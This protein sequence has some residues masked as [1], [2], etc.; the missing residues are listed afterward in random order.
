MNEPV[1]KE[2]RERATSGHDVSMA[3]SA[4]AGSGKTTVLVRRIVETLVCGRVLPREVAA[5]TFTEKAAGELSAR[6]RDALEKK[7]REAGK[8]NIVEQILSELPELT[9]STIHTFCQDLLRHESLEAEFAPDTT[10]GNERAEEQILSELLVD[11]KT[12]F[13]ERRAEQARV[14]FELSSFHTLLR[15][16]KK[17]FQYR[18]YRDRTSD[19]AFDEGAAFSELK[20]IHAAIVKAMSP[21]KN[22]DGCKLIKKARALLDEVEGALK[23]PVSDGVFLCLTSDEAA[24]GRNVGSQK[25]WPGESK[26]AFLRE[27]AEVI[28][29]RTRWRAALHAAVI[30]DMREHLLPAFQEEKRRQS[31]AGF[32]DLLF[33]AAHLLKKSTA[34]RAR[35]AQRYKVILVDEVQDTDPIQAE[36]A[37]LLASAVPDDTIATTLRWEELSPS[38]GRLFAVGDPKQSIYRFRGADVDTFK[39]LVGAISKSGEQHELS[40]NFRSVP[41]IVSWVNYVFSELP[42][43]AAQEGHRKDAELSPVVA[44]YTPVTAAEGEEETEDGEDG[45]ES[46]DAPA[47]DDD[48]SGDADGELVI[49][50]IDAVIR[51]LSS[52]RAAQARVV[53]RES[54]ELR[55]LTWSDVMVLLP[56]WSMADTIAD[57]FRA[58][59]IECAVEGGDQFFVRD[60]VRLGTALLRAIVEPADTE[61]VVF[62]L[63]G[64]FG[65]SHDELATHK[66]LGGAFRYT[67]PNPPAGRVADALKVLLSAHR[68]RSS[69]SL[70]ELLDEVFSATRALS[71]WRLLPDG[72]SRLANIDKLLSMI[73]KAE[74]ECF[75]P[76]AVAEELMRQARVAKD[77]D[78]DRIDDDGDAVR[79][80]SL[81]KAKGLEASVVVMMFC[82]RGNGGMTSVVDHSARTIAVTLGARLLPSGWTELTASE[83]KLD[84]EER[85]RWMYVAATRARDQL[86][87]VPSKKQNLLDIEIKHRGLPKKPGKIDHGAPM[88]LTEGVVVN[89]EHASELPPIGA[90]LETFPGVDGLLESAL[91]VPA[92]RG[93]P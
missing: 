24:P 92:E 17:L 23:L 91:G 6:V 88:K 93:R 59:G 43:Y 70:V 29:W 46:G 8:S 44:L 28:S 74:S 56:S 63:R 87:I 20:D 79:I 1:D 89:V 15:A 72:L 55:K 10:I 76:Y 60:E 18:H 41:G 84:H 49:D 3:L 25:D 80:T 31:I 19:V 65:L 33:D 73:R 40:Q 4:G 14:L 16:A 39:R 81:F 50:E 66:K 68:G 45:A 86:V 26:A 13:R 5:V 67:L 12:H 36:V 35:L 9:L 38:P 90:S 21:C 54:D 22:Q 82:D 32:D 34:A 57:R 47:D 30:A 27:V 11:W 53:D 75:S 58:A 61:A 2:A 37:T 69:G 78:I 51:H 77:K 83:A 48:D 62:V 52:L 7:L 71:V 85:R 64:L 42:G